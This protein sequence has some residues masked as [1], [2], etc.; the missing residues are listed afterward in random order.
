M[1]QVETVGAVVGSFSREKHSIL[2]GTALEEVLVTD[3][4]EKINL[5][6]APPIGGENWMLNVRPAEILDAAGLEVISLNGAP[7]I[8]PLK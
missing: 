1:K 7:F 6:S 5:G 3:S 2:G 4:G 8:E